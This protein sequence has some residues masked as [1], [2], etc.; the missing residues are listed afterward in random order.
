MHEG[1]K[2]R[3]KSRKDNAHTFAVSELRFWFNKEGEYSVSLLDS[4]MRK[5]WPRF[6]FATPQGT[7]LVLPCLAA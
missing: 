7:G 6:V 5:S 1:W 2:L 3:L 4:N